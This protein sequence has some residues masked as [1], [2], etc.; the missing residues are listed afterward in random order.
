[1]LLVFT[2]GGMYVWRAAHH[3]F[4]PQKKKKGKTHHPSE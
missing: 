2:G 1:M 4:R 3:D